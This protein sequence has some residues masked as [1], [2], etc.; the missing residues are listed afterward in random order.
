MVQDN[1]RM[2]MGILLEAHRKSESGVFHSYISGYFMPKL[3]I[4]DLTT[5]EIL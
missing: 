2:R 1:T 4:A 3:V 5:K